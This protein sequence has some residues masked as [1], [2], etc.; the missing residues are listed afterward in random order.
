MGV[1]SADEEGKPRGAVF[2][3]LLLKDYH[4][5]FRNSPCFNLKGDF[6][7]YQNSLKLKKISTR[8]LCFMA[9][10]VAITMILSAISGYLRIGDSIKFSISFISVYVGA[11]IYGP[12]AGGTI[13]AVADIVSFIMNPTGP[14]IPVFT[15]ME[16]INGVFFGLFLYMNTGKKPS[17]VKV[18]FMTFVCAMLQ[19]CVNMFWRTYELA[20][21]YDWPFWAKFIERLPSNVVMVICKIVVI[22]LLAPHMTKFRAMV[23]N[24]K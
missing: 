10:L 4:I 13:A 9:M 5:L 17:L 18:G 23:V 2:H 8:D 11:A 20:M 21:L 16:F 22:I 15:V 6:F 14:Y 12:V 19:F 1:E 24:K 3:P 7:M